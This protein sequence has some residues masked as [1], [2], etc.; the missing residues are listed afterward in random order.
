[1]VG[2]PT[3]RLH[4]WTTGPDVM[5]SIRS[6]E[7]LPKVIYRRAFPHRTHYDRLLG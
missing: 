5:F 3:E 2:I 4:K 1:M 7:Q 6:P